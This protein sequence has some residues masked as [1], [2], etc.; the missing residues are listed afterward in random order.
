MAAGKHADKLWS[1][2]K[3]PRTAQVPS[4]WGLASAST[5]ASI[6]VEEGNLETGKKVPLPETSK[7][8]GDINERSTITA[9]TAS[10]YY[11][12]NYWN[13]FDQVRSYMNSLSTGNPSVDWKEHL[14]AWNGRK[15]FKKAMIISCGNGFV[16]RDL[17]SK[18]II[19]SAVGIDVNEQLLDAARTEAQKYDLPVRYYRVDSNKE[20]TFPEDGYDIVVNHAALHHIAYIDFHVRAL[21][22]LLQRSPGGVLVNYDYVG[23]H[24]NQYD[25]DTWEMIIA[26]DKQSDPCFRLPNINQGYPHIQTMLALDQSEAIHSELIMSVLDRYFEP[27]WLRY[28]NGALAYTLLTHNKNLQQPCSTGADLAEHIHKVLEAD[29]KYTASHRGSELFVYSIMKP[30]TNS[31]S[32]AVEDV[33]SREEDQRER[34]AQQNG[35]VY[36]SPTVVSSL[37]QG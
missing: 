30:R 10:V 35:G 37:V 5:S 8:F 2:V 13:D 28:L 34:A 18:G 24:R 31:P 14:F 19:L 23:P 15:P 22:R 4:P 9:S 7:T 21:S 12:G 16:E 3:D 27:L 26:L 20:D 36:Y 17:L 6:F 32:R 11:S 1:F 33:W 29:S 25:A